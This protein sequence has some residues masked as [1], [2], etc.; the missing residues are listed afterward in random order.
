MGPTGPTN[1]RYVLLVLA[2]ILAT[3]HLDQK[4]LGLAMQDI[5]KEFLLSDTQLGLLTGI[6][7]S[8]FYSVLGVPLARWA[9]R[10]DR[11]R[12]IALTTAIWSAAIALCGAATNFIQLLAIRIAVAVGEAGCIPTSQSLIA[13]LYNRDERPKAVSLYML[14]APAATL[15]GFLF[16]GWLIQYYGWRVTFLLLSVP[17]IVLAV[18]AWTTLRDPRRDAGGI[19]ASSFKGPVSEVPSFRD[20]ARHLATNTTFRYVLLA[21][22]VF[23]FFGYGIQNWQ[24]TFFIRSFGLETGELGTWLALIFGVG[25]LIGVWVG[26]ELAMRFAPSDESLQLKGTALAYVFF[27]VVSS[28][29]YLATDHRVAF[30]FMALAALGASGAVGPLFSTI[31]TLVPGHMRAQA[32]AL[33]YFVANFVGLGLGPLAA[34]IVSDLFET[35][36]GRESLRYTLLVM[37][38]GYCLGGWLLWRAS[39]TVKRDVQE[40]MGPAEALSSP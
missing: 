32:A 28:C 2:L 17:A 21:F 16:G 20:V 31:Q 5:K 37:S 3:N 38:P 6:A 14:G 19:G 27:G 33:V 36:L 34:G 40:S 35:L 13:S 22:T 30:A 24:P 29:T 23:Y 10:G 15:V 7:F 4:V 18:L 26:G 25:G 12:V 1:R 9:D 8:L 11:V 39:K